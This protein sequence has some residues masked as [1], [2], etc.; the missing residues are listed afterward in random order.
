[1]S[2]RTT[3]RNIDDLLAEVADE[4]EAAERTADPDAPLPE[5]VKITRPG[6]ARSK[7]LQVRLNPDE[8]AA[9]EAIA[10]RR[11]LPVSTVAREQIL[12]LLA[13]DAAFGSTGSPLRRYFLDAADRANE[14]ADALRRISHMLRSESVQRALAELDEPAFLSMGTT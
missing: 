4:A 12:Q 11:G 1:M 14:S 13:D 7:V 8:M 2:R 10:E 3:G 9:V 5:H 6:H